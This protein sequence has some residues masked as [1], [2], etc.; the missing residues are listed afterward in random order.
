MLCAGALVAALLAAHP[1]AAQ[2]TVQGR[3]ALDFGI[4]IQG[5]NAAVVPT[6]AVRAGQFYVLE[7][8]G[9]MI[10]LSLTLPTNLTTGGQNLKITFAATDGVIRTT[11]AGA[12]STVFSP[13]A[14]KTVTLSSSPDIYVELGGTIKPTALQVA[15]HYTGTVI[16][17][18]TVIS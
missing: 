4:A 7:H 11:G 6:D 1:A 8:V 12:T 5:V 15:G 2:V 3:Q 16:L 13:K 10:R 14:A 18:I 9:G 17:T